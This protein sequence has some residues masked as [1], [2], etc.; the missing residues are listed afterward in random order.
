ML[1]LIRSEA[2]K[3]LCQRSLFA[4]GFLVV[5]AFALLVKILMQ[6]MIFRR[7][8]VQD[9]PQDVDILAEAAQSFSVSGNT[10]AH[11]FFA[12]GVASI[13]VVEYRF[14]TWRH[15]VPRR[16]RFELWLAKF[17]VAGLCLAMS[18]FLVALG[19]L[20][21]TAL[22][23]M[24]GE[25]PV[26]LLLQAKSMLPFGLAFLTAMLELLVLAAL[27]AT[28]TMALRSSMA[29][30]LIAFLLTLATVL[31]QAYLGPSQELW[32]LPSEAA[33][34]MR[35]ALA[36]SQS[37][38]FLASGAVLVGWLL[39]AGGLGAAVFARQELATE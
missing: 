17:L 19:N 30:V 24:V 7:A 22:M 37:Q 26:S 27:T 13:F 9:F 12:L 25:R 31:L 20:V 1:L 8:G 38:K 18:L 15:L 14:S 36:T 4:A 16:S 39:V 3:I 32:W 33:N 11:L 28:L 21:L 10:L 5:P 23:A 35:E 29:A 6:F 34:Q 2:Q